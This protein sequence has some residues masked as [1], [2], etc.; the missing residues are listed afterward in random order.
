MKSGP[1]TKATPSPF[2][3]ARSALVSVPSAR[4]SQRKYPPWGT[5]KTASGIF[6]RSASTSASQRAFSS[7]LTN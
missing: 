4:S 5:T 7:P 3:S 1:A 6:S 2:D